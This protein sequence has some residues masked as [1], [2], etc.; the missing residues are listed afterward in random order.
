MSWRDAPLYVRV[1]DLACD[2]LPRVEEGPCASLR[3]RIAIEVQELLCEVALALSFVPGWAE[4]QQAAD[5]AVTR[6]K[7][8]LRLARELGV[9]DV[10]GARHAGEM[11]VEIG[12]MIGGWQRRHAAGRPRVASRGAHGDPP[13]NGT[14]PAGEA[15]CPAPGV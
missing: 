2:L 1:H 3:H 12:R 6:L 15:S 13:G 5:R 9:L 11:V 14:D 7:V 10:R 8:L 4:H